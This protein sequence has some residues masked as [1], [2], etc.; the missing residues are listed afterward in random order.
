MQM[1]M[2]HETM[3]IYIKTST[4]F[5]LIFTE[6]APMPNRSWKKWNSN[7]IPLLKVMVLAIFKLAAAC[8][9]SG[10]HN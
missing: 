6:Q 5:M 1:Y 4:S 9:S 10:V 8:P 2:P 7:S 3:R